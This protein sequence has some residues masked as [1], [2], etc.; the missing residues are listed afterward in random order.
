MSIFL[1]KRVILCKRERERTEDYKKCDW[2]D[3]Q[4]QD[5]DDNDHDHYYQYTYKNNNN[6]PSFLQQL[7]YH[8]TSNELKF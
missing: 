7:K 3:T 6:S 4:K 8:L 1:N 2:V 5:S